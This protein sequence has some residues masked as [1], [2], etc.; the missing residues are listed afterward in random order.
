MDVALGT[1]SEYLVAALALDQRALSPELGEQL[2]DNV[3]NAVVRR[4]GR[5]APDFEPLLGPL[6]VHVRYFASEFDARLHL[7]DVRVGDI[8]EGG[9]GPD[10]LPDVSREVLDANCAVLSGL[11]DVD[12]IVLLPFLEVVAAVLGELLAF[13]VLG[14]EWLGAAGTVDVLDP[15]LGLLVERPG[16]GV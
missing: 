7:G 5:L 3:S 10:V 11:L 9:T 14:G 1:V 8:L 15:C 6:R 16:H 12:Y 4:H 13:D 2:Y